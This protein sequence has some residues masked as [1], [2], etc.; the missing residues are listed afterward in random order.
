MSGVRDTH[1]ADDLRPKMQRVAGALH[2][3]SG[4]SGH[5]GFSLTR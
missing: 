2:A 4:K 5:I 3:A 1:L